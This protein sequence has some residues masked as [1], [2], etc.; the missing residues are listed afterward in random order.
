MGGW[1]GGGELLGVQTSLCPSSAVFTRTLLVLGLDCAV[2]R[3]CS[4]LAK[5]FLHIFTFEHMYIFL[6]RL[7]CAE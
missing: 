1:V 7:Q 6:F 5:E 4:L 3:H 2:R